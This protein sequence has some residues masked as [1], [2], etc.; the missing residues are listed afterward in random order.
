MLRK[1][2][3]VF[4][5]MCIGITLMWGNAW[6]E[7][8][9]HPNVT[10]GEGI[11][12]NAE[13]NIPIPDEEGFDPAY[14]KED[15]KEATEPY[16]PALVMAARDRGGAMPTI[17]F[18]TGPSSEEEDTCDPCECYGIDCIEEP[19]E[20]GSY[21]TCNNTVSYSI[22]NIKEPR[23]E[24]IHPSIV[25]VDR[26]AQFRF[27]ATVEYNV[28]LDQ[29][30]EE[31]IKLS[32]GSTRDGKSIQKSDIIATLVYD[33][34]GQGYDEFHARSLVSQDP[35]VSVKPLIV[36]NGTFAVRWNKVGEKP[37]LGYGQG[38]QEKIMGVIV[39]NDFN[40]F[41]KLD[42]ITFP[43]SWQGKKPSDMKSNDKWNVT[44]PQ[45]TQIK[46]TQDIDNNFDVD[47]VLTDGTRSDVLNVQGF[48]SQ[49][50]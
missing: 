41:K 17:N 27:A 49:A 34:N 20:E 13:F 29:T 45:Q 46:L 32:D 18:Y 8:Q 44:Y 48:G 14:D 9:I 5:V 38:T 2:C 4:T 23:Y 22:A 39:L 37:S 35:N 7:S 50:Q 6:A 28:H 42:E 31:T 10:Q 33:P 24:L 16:R 12:P 47:F 30:C 11:D 40:K 15:F 36:S 3:R 25:F 1:W 26:E 19:S 43:S 21:W